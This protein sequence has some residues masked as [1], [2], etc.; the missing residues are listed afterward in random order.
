MHDKNYE[1][2]IPNFS[3]HS[4]LFHKQVVL[5]LLTDCPHCG[6]PNPL[7]YLVH[8]IRDCM[9]NDCLHCNEKFLIEYQAK[10]VLSTEKAIPF[11]FDVYK[12]ELIEPINKSYSI[13]ED[14]D[15]DDDEEDD[16][17]EGNGNE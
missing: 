16:E 14:D 1:S 5:E 4:G 9:I 10:K 7:Q 2:E 8:M 11:D 12:I 6:K 3:E 17:D 15:E 13:Y